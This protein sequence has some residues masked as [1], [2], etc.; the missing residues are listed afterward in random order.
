MTQLEMI[1]STEASGSGSASISPFRNSTFVAPAL[2]ALARASA[3]MSSVMSTPYANPDV[4][5]RRA[6]SKTS[7][8]PPEPRS[9][10]RSPSRRSATASGLPHPRLARTAS[11]GSSSASPSPYNWA[12]DQSAPSSAAEPVSQQESAAELPQQPADESGF[13]AMTARAASAYRARTSS[14][15]SVLAWSVMTT[16]PIHRSLS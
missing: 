16:T 15:K 9:R 13:G 5:T 14:R 10:T 11:S 7:I 8:P 1:T 4:P 12:A 3:S 6:D 2:T